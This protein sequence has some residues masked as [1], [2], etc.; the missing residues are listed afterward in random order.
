MPSFPRFRF[1]LF[2]VVG[3]L[4]V[5]CTSSSRDAGSSAQNATQASGPDHYLLL[6]NTAI[7]FQMTD[8]KFRQFDKSAYDGISVA[9]L[10]AYDPSPSPSVPS[11]DA[12]LA[13]WKGSTGKDI[14]PWVYVN[15]MIGKNPKEQNS[16]SDIP[17]FQ[18]IRGADFNDAHGAQS[19]FL[20]IWRNSL[21]AARDSK[22]PGVFVDLEFY[23]NY[24]AYDV[25][26]LA[27]QTGTK[28]ADVTTS[29]QKV[30]RR[31]ADIASQEYP[32]A[33]LWFAFMGLTHPTYK[34][35]DGVPYYPSPS[36]ISMGLLDE[37]VEKGMRMRVLAGGEG[38]I[39]YCHDTLQSFQDAIRQ[40]E[41]D[42]KAPLDKYKSVPLELAGTMTLWS[43]NAVNKVCPSSTAGS[44]ED[45]QPYIELM[46]K[47][48]RY[49]WIWASSG[50]GNYNA[51]APD[52]AP[53]FDAVIRRAKAAAYAQ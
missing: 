29:L 39:A 31:M 9:F 13:Q 35:H 27:R 40:R 16:H 17:Y 25:G 10:H 45:L 2:I 1:G 15:R 32:T 38:S 33:T 34:T 20:Q 36:Y 22:M 37:M 19:D 4:A 8:A 46:M 48:Y 49:D 52:S 21:A 50:E 5:T 44:V 41:S 6:V 7:A 12:Q 47:S 42:M 3:C 18:S 28:P 14:W 43:D 26:E 11:M 23:N 24:A 53:R 51:F 30:G